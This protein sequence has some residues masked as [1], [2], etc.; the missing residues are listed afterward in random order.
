MSAP[1]PVHLHP[2][3][4][5]D[6]D[7]A[8]IGWRIGPGLVRFTGDVPAGEAPP[9]VRAL[10]DDAVLTAVHV[11]PGRIETRLAPDRTA[12]GDGARIR[13]ALYT[14]LAAE[15]GWRR[16]GAD[17]EGPAIRAAADRE[18]AERVRAVLDG[19]F[20]DYTA[21]HGGSVD[22]VGVTDGVVNV[23]LNGSCHGCA[24]ADN[25]VRQNLEGRLRV[26]PGFRGIAVVGDRNCATS[27]NRR[28]SLKLRRLRRDPDGNGA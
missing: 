21:S 7:P 18:I 17:E 19:D 10:F 9:P 14:V 22:L 2:E 6:G 11:S 8:V 12:A 28:V 3:A 20:G 25:T 27:D 16:D 23:V 24:A 15:G 4:A 26:I 13:S 1:T 5:A